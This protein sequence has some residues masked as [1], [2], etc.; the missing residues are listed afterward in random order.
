LRGA[1]FCQF[2]SD[3]C[4]GKCDFSHGTYGSCL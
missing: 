3:C 1:S 4:T 2:N